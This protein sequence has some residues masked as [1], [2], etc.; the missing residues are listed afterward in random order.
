MIPFSTCTCDIFDILDPENGYISFYFD[1]YSPPIV[2]VKVLQGLRGRRD[3]L[4]R[5]EGEVSAGRA[6]TSNLIDVS[7][8]SYRQDIDAFRRSMFFLTQS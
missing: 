7:A 5:P 3:G 1:S 4:L 6:P 2:F 8:C